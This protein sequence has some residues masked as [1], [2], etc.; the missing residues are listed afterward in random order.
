MHAFTRTL[1]VS[2]ALLYGAFALTGNTWA[3][4]GSASAL[5]QEERRVFEQMLPDD[6][7]DFELHPEPRPF[8]AK[9]FIGPDGKPMDL[10]AFEGKVT[11]LNF[12]AIWCPPCRKEL[13]YLNNLQTMLG[14]EGVEVVTIS[15]DKAGIKKA[16]PYL[17]KHNLDE[18]RAYTDP[19]ANLSR[20][21]GVLGLPVTAILGPDAREIG[22]FLGEAQW[23]SQEV[24]E[25][26]RFIVKATDDQGQAT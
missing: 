1:A 17:E 5:D 26:L 20:E 12:W 11:V 24:Q 25:W 21:M 3:K 6:L 14:D 16:K 23:D 7:A 4:D 2:A 22:R 13:P 10:S 9:E 19:K 15:L 8:R 18:L